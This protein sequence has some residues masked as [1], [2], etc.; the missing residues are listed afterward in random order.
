MTTNLGGLISL[1]IMIV[2][3]MFASLKM[4]HLL[5]NHNPYVNE[6]ILHGSMEE[7]IFDPAAE[8]FVMAFAFEAY[9][10]NAPLDDQNFIK[11]V[12]SVWHVE[13]D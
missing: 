6:H 9:A 5:I 2:T 4:S 1:A 10:D 12:A 11:F 8:D 7:E 13:P 3:F